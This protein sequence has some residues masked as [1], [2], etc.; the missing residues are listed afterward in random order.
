MF[1]NQSKYQKHNYFMRL[2]LSQAEVS[3]GNTNTNP[4]VGCVIVKNN[5][6]ISAAS[7]SPTGRPHAEQNA[8]NISKKFSQ[9]SSLY[10]TLEP[11]IH[12]GKTPP[13][14]KKIIKNKIKKV[15]FSIKDPDFRTF[16]KS[17][18]ILRKKGVLVKSGL[19]SKE[20]TEFYRSYIKFKKNELPFVTCKLACSKDFFI[21]N[22]KNKWITNDLSRGRVHLMRSNHDCIITGSSTVIKDNPKLTCRINGML[23]KTPPRVILDSKL[24]VPISSN[25]IKES[26]IYKTII[27]Y[28]KMNKKKIMLLKKS[29][30]KVFK[31]PLNKK[32]E[33]NLRI[34]LIKLKKIGFSRI[35][36][37][38]GLKLTNSFFRENLIDDFKLFISNKNLGSNGVGSIKKYF[39][40]FLKNKKKIDIKVNLVGDRLISY[41][42]K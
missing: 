42:L 17:S 20:I 35:F 2:A 24:S 10:V 3:L 38:S 40:L 14:V 41:K 13:C 16:A 33:L 11:C 8:I 39:K 12:Y 34:C 29:K 15:F 18:K 23:H 32:G 26:H 31:L 30:V 5:N 4:A 19:L 7:T 22:K 25:L 6:V 36:L 28:N 27:F 21:V 37:E 9:K 1:T